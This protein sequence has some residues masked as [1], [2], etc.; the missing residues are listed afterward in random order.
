MRL[1]QERLQ[2]LYPAPSQAFVTDALR[3]VRTLPTQQEVRTM[4]YIPKKLIVAVALALA[5]LTTTAF[6][7][8]RPAVL[9]WLLGF[10][11]ASP[12]LSASVQTIHAEGKA[13][14]VTIRVTSLV[15]DGNSLA[16]SYEA[17][18]DD[19]TMAARFQMDPVF[20]MNGREIRL[21]RTSYA[22]EMSCVPTTHLDVAPVKRNPTTCGQWVYN[23]G[24]LSGEVACEMTFHIYRPEKA[25][26][27]LIDAED[28][29]R[30]ID[31]QGPDFQA[32]L[33]DK[34]NCL[35]SL[36]NV[37]IPDAD[38]QD[39]AY[40]VAQGYTVADE[41]L[42][43]TGKVVLNF[44]FDADMVQ[45]FDCSDGEDV[46]LEG[47]TLRIAT[48]RLSPLQTLIDLCIIPEENTEKAAQALVAQHGDCLL[49]DGDGTPLVFSKMDAMWS[50]SPW[51]AQR[52]GQWGIHYLVERPGLL[53]FPETVVFMTEA[54][55]LLRLDI[56]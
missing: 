36:K 23:V 16:F 46:A 48:F 26:A 41:N 21:D 44:T 43:E 22:P 2:A 1:D 42:R 17:E 50:M 8:T 3:L 49:T 30:H 51:A 25:I 9:D 4:R 28:P 35:T 37:I 39:A 33:R 12:E 47:A 38:R 24:E 31:E 27:Y 14:G 10:S 6:A 53:T 18:T 45:G 56:N 5:M 11:D 19:P 54:G 20:T 40:W 34:W 55:E 7:L 13:D 15:W 52:D 32:D 29:L